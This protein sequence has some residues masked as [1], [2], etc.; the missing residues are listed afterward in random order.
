M[1]RSRKITQHARGQSCQINF[2]NVCNHNQET[3][4]FAHLNG[5]GKGL[6]MKAPDYAGFFACSACHERYDQKPH[7]I[8]NLDEYLLRAVLRTWAILIADGIIDVSQDQ[9]KTHIPSKAIS[10]KSNFPK[11]RKISGRPFPKK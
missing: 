3:T 10:K 8:A 6:G 4:V 5:H 11:G 2:E 9:P 1:I 7:E